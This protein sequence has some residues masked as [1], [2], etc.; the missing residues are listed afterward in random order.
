MKYKQT[1][2]EGLFLCEPLVF[3][4]ERGYFM[5]TYRQTEFEEAHGAAIQF[6]QE[7]ESFSKRGVLRG[8]HLQK[9][10]AAQAK[11]VRCL[12][13]RVIDVAI[14]LRAK[15]PTLGQYKWVELSAENKLQF[16]IPR[17]FAHGFIT[18]SHEA[19]FSYKVDNIYSPEDEVC[20]RFDDPTV[21]IPWES[22]SFPEHKILLKEKDRLGISFIEIMERKLV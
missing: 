22:F 15:S 6:V 13:G 9:G 8:M 3:S 12:S 4:D 10:E 21:A 1:E 20:M 19:V 5:E 2:I 16:F 11:L 14:D 17:G 18:L 7:N